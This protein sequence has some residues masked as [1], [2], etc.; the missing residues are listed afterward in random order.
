MRFLRYH[1]IYDSATPANLNAAKSSTT[2]EWIVQEKIHG[3][4]FSIHLGHAAAG[5]PGGGVELR[6]GKR[7][8][9]LDLESDTF[10]DF[11]RLDDTLRGS[12]EKLWSLTRT[13]E[14]PG[15]NHQVAI[16]GE[17]FGG[18]LP[19]P[20]D[21]ESGWDAL[22]KRRTAPS[23]K[24]SRAETAISAAPVQE[25]V[26]YSSRLNFVVFDIVDFWEVDGRAFALRFWPYDRVKQVAEQC[27]FLVSD[28]LL[29]TGS[30]A[31][32]A[33]FDVSR[34]TS[35]LASKL[36]PGSDVLH[37]FDNLAEGV[38]IRPASVDDVLIH[39]DGSSKERDLIM[40]QRFMLKKKHARFAEEIEN[41]DTCFADTY[42]ARFRTRIAR[43]ANSNRL[44]AVLSKELGNP[45]PQ[46]ASHLHQYKLWRQE[47]VSQLGADVWEAFWEKDGQLGSVD[48]DLADAYIAQEA[49]R[50]VD[51]RFGAIADG[52]A[53]RGA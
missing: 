21:A 4:N 41:C 44:A 11:Q 47:A 40:P 19:S 29:R 6:Y 34:L 7:N 33:N 52:P 12:A 35:Q 49:A 22:F 28:A 42:E 30:Y 18:W 23:A 37:D 17:L 25:G 15:K 45:P 13:D 1:K 27:G 53:P 20:K 2:T 9:F 46:D 16:Y 43:L 31:E 51:E 48:Y 14:P 24:T 8:G 36:N 32:A 39:V 5:R 10:Y 3:S 38:V 26:Y 50:V